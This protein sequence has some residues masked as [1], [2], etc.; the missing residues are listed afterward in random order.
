MIIASYIWQTALLVQAS[1]GSVETALSL[2]QEHA[3]LLNQLA[4]TNPKGTSKSAFPD[5]QQARPQ[6]G[7][8]PPLPL[9]SGVA[10]LC[11]Q[12]S[13]QTN[14]ARAQTP[15]S[16]QSSLTH[17]ATAGNAAAQQ[18]LTGSN[19]A[20]HGMAAAGRLAPLLPARAS[21]TGLTVN[22]SLISRLVHTQGSSTG[23]EQPNATPTPTP[24]GRAVYSSTDSADS[25]QVGLFRLALCMFMCMPSEACRAKDWVSVGVL[26]SAPRLQFRA[27]LRACEEQN[28]ALALPTWWHDWLQ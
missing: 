7:E 20:L 27:L 9:S 6:T 13:A 11:T 24:H 5:K 3:G 14:L 4:D 21:L 25:V 22:N 8:E 26:G 10:A 16:A 23:P 19:D 17:V 1:R 2:L 28:D 18:L 15:T 12:S